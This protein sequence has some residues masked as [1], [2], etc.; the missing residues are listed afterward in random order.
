MSVRPMPEHELMLYYI[1]RPTIINLPCSCPLSNLSTI[2]NSEIAPW[3]LPEFKLSSS[4]LQLAKDTYVATAAAFGIIAVHDVFDNIQ[5]LQSGIESSL[6]EKDMKE[7]LEQV[8]KEV[9]KEG[10]KS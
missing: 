5:R 9:K 3:V 1:G 8:I 6:T 2:F 4:Q 10:P 7:Y